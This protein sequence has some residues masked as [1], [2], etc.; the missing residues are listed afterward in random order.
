MTSKPPEQ[1]A[2][3]SLSHPPAFSPAPAS[4][5]QRRLH[6]SYRLTSSLTWW[7]RRR[8]PKGGWLVILSIIATG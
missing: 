4:W 3:N 5:L 8:F 2:T 6:A 7:W 1:P